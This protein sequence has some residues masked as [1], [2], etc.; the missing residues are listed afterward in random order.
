V[1]VKRKLILSEKF[2]FSLPAATLT[3]LCVIGFVVMFTGQATRHA[4]KSGILQIKATPSGPT[5]S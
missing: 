1:E 3:R 2:I 5:H 4:L